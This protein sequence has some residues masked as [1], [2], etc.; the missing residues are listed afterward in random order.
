MVCVAQAVRVWTVRPEWPPTHRQI[1]AQECMSIR[2]VR[3]HNFFA[4]FL[5]YK[6]QVAYMHNL[7]LYFFNFLKILFQHLHTINQLS[8]RKFLKFFKMIL[9]VKPRLNRVSIFNQ[10]MFDFFFFL[11]SFPNSIIQIKVTFTISCYNYYISNDCQNLL[12]QVSN[13]FRI[14][15]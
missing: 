14:I 3:R 13:H 15:L 6:I 8:Q 11:I 7:K 4:P 9:H 1:R 12:Y 5:F 10:G 2:S